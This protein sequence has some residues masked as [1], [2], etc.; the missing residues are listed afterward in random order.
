MKSVLQQ[1]YEGE[2]APAE[3]YTKRLQEYQQ[4]LHENGEYIESF[5]EKLSKINADLGDQFMDILEKHWQEAPWEYTQVF[6][7]SFCLGARIML[8][9]C[10]KEFGKK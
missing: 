9:I 10:E 1:L 7:D 8:E 4:L 5:Q 6:L 2:I 3:L